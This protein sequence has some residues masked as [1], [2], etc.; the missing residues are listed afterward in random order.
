MKYIPYEKLSKAKKREIDSKKRVTWNNVK[1]VTIVHKGVKDYKRK[2][3][4]K[5]ES[6]AYLDY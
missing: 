2:F 4:T 6:E 3:K 5:K 1:P